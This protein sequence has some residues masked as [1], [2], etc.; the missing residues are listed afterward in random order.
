MIN[1]TFSKSSKFFN[2]IKKII[3]EDKITNHDSSITNIFIKIK[4]YIFLTNTES[5]FII[6][7]TKT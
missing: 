1:K 6:H 4:K 7:L 5:L 2:E 3:L